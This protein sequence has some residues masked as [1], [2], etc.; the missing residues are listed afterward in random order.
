MNLESDL[1]IERA[2]VPVGM[3]RSDKWPGVRAAWLKIQPK[4]AVCDGVEKLEVH[5]Q[6]PFHLHPELELDE[7]NFITLCEANKEGFDC[8]LG[9]GHLGCFRSFNVDVVVDAAIWNAKIKNRPSVEEI[10]LVKK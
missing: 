5:H 3:Q 6:K 7:R 9:Y 1:Q 10:E 8:H 4:C 2:K